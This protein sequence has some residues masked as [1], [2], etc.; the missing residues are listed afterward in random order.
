MWWTLSLAV[1]AEP[2]PTPANARPVD[3]RLEHV[4][5]ETP[6][7]PPCT[8][9]HA[10]V[11]TPVKEARATSELREGSLVHAASRAIDGDAKTAW[12]EGDAGVGLGQ[13]LRL[14]V[15]GA[16]PQGLMV[17][18]G[19]A[20]DAERWRKNQRVAVARVQWLKPADDSIDPDT[21]WASDQLV[22]TST[23]PLLVRFAT[24]DGALPV[25]K[26]QVIDFVSFWEQNM[27]QT[28][29]VAIDLVI[30][31][32][33]GTGA[34]YEDTVISEVSWLNLGPRK[35]ITCAPGWCASQGERAA[36][37]DGC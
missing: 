30:V 6:A 17:T 34:A 7:M 36:T 23:E 20:K 5:H 21:A 3:A 24:V 15:E 32:V 18:P 37:I 1:A 9:T 33:E 10:V 35:E 14:R 22:P 31:E 4:L 25:G 16:F 29:V 27:E 2:L 8:S 19:Y 13:A 28:E 26:A 12:V 11:A